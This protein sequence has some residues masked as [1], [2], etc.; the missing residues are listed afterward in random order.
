MNNKELKSV[1][2]AAVLA[3]CA[4]GSWAAD[5]EHK[6]SFA[7]LM[8]SAAAQQKLDGSVRLYLQGQKTPKV[9]ETKGQ[10]VSNKKTNAFGK[11]AT[12]TCQWAA[13]SA[14]L[15]LQEKAK[16]L[17]ANAVI[18]IVSYYKKDAFSSPTDYECHV[19]AI[20]SGVAFKG[21]YAKVAQ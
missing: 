9:L 20:M 19:G 14:L 3:A 18:D 8:E 12:T 2:V 15:A 11:D 21:T 17:G 5:A 6:M 1:L 4:A 10:D 7:E 16:R 13:L